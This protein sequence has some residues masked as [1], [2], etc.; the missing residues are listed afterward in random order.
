MYASSDLRKYIE[1]KIYGKFVEQFGKNIIPYRSD[2]DMLYL[3]RSISLSEYNI[4]RN[5][6]CKAFS[7]D[8]GWHQNTT[9]TKKRLCM[10][11]HLVL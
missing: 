6:C 4:F 11:K 7:S 2:D 8:F 1:N 10:L 3:I 5:K 9:V